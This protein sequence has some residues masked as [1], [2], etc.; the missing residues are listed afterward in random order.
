M[1]PEEVKWEDGDPGINLH[2]HGVPVRGG[3]KSN[4]HVGGLVSGAGRGRGGGAKELISERFSPYT[5]WGWQEKFGLQRNTP[6][7]LSHKGGLH[8][9][10]I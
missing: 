3:K 7:R 8:F 10:G 5:K 4:N 2:G 6:Y 9:K 1:G